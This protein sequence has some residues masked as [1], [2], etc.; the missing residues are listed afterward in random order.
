MK[1]CECHG[2]ENCPAKKPPKKD[3]ILIELSPSQIHSIFYSLKQDEK[4]K[5]TLDAFSKAVEKGWRK[6]C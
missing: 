4:F 2:V 1:T 3:L 5:E 6:L